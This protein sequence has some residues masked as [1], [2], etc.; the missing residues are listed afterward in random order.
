MK[1]PIHIVPNGDL[2]EHIV[3]VSCWCKPVEE[4]TANPD[5]PMFIHNAADGREF[6]EKESQKKKD[7]H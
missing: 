5:A 4:K 1:D 3:H 6:F 2:K 7:G